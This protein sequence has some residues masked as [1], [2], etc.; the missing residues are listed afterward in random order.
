MNHVSLI[1]K[2]LCKQYKDVTPSGLQFQQSSA[3]TFHTGTFTRSSCSLGATCVLSLS[4]GVE[5]ISSIWMC[6][7]VFMQWNFPRE[8][9]GKLITT[10]V[11]DFAHV[12]EYMQKAKYYVCEYF[13]QGNIIGA[14]AYVPTIPVLNMLC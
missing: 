7:A 10:V 5:G 12:H 8:L 9:W 13:P 11:L 1:F 6:A 2:H 14:F 3:V 4:D